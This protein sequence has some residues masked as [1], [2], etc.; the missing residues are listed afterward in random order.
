MTMNLR[1][2][3]IAFVVVCGLGI[4]LL[5]EP[6]DALAGCNSGNVANT[7][8]LSSVNCE[9]NASGTSSTA[10]G[11]LAV[12]TGNFSTAI[13][14]ESGP[15]AA[16]NGV[17]SVGALANFN[18][19][20]TFSTAIGAGATGT[21]ATQSSGD[22]SVAIGG[23][24]GVLF[25]GA[26]AIGNFSVVVG[27]NSTA[28][29]AASVFGTSATANVGGTALGNGAR[30][31]GN[32]T[33]FANDAAVAVGNIANAS[34]NGSV[35]VGAISAATGTFSTALGTASQAQAANS[36]AIG[37]GRTGSNAAA[38][39]GAA[40]ANGIAIGSNANVTAAGGIALGLNTSATFANSTAIGG[41]AVTAR[42]NQVAVGTAANTYT[43]AGVTSAASLAAQTGPTQVVTTDAFGNLAAASFTPQDISTLQS[44]VGVLQQNVSVLQTQMRQAFEGTAIAIAL[45]GASLPADKRFAISTNWGNFRGQNAVGVAAQYRITD[46][47]VA[48]LGVGGGF[49]QGGI[50]SRAGVTFAW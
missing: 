1:I 21:S 7:D 45:G 27:T 11:G 20:G 38:N 28:S 35:A 6:S 5:A 30:A 25:N 29:A 14:A 32:T 42:V 17:T 15:G 2:L 9:A 22:F 37:G 16:V 34:Q 4:G 44:N 19:P 47:A 48:N 49:A 33:T 46:Y 13:G 36:I 40:A 50:G 26:K 41:G 18:T 10:V 31:T 3:R 23:G 8:L 24:D 43:L 39:V 12:A